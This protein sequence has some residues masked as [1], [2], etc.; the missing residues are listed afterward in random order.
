M[1]KALVDGDTFKWR[2]AAAGEYVNY[3]LSNDKVIRTATET[4]KY[5]LFKPDVYVVE[6]E[7]VLDSVDKVLHNVKQCM[8]EIVNVTGDGRPTIYIGKG[9]TF[10]HQFYNLYKFNRWEREKPYHYGNVLDYLGEYYDVQIV[11]EIEADDAIATA[12]TQD[13]SAI[14]CSQDK[15]LFQVPGR[16]FNFVNGEKNEITPREAGVFLFRQ[17]LTGDSTDNI[18]GVKGVGAK[19]AENIIPMDVPKNEVYELAESQ[20]P[21]AADFLLNAELVFLRRKENQGFQEWCRE[22]GFL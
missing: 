19:A 18:P 5:L 11:T 3:H 9:A 2:Y 12:A 4:K 10:R 7:R 1:P 21:S 22:H 15:D 14:I 6:I 16:H 13:Q 20:F 17:I 8:A